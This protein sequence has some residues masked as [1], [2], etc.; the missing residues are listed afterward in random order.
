MPASP[1]VC[2]VVFVLCCGEHEPRPYSVVF[3]DELRPAW[4]GLVKPGPGTVEWWCCCVVVAG[5]WDR[6]HYAAQGRL[7]ASIRDGGGEFDLFWRLKITKPRRLR[8]PSKI[9]PVPATRSSRQLIAG[10]LY[11]LCAPAYLIIMKNDPF[12]EKMATGP[13]QGTCQ[14]RPAKVVRFTQFL[15]PND[16]PQTPDC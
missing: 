15:L 8:H 16:P 4:P 7:L 5:S 10:V 1:G 6:P 2:R 3:R 9:K 11:W 13:G 14:S 12:L